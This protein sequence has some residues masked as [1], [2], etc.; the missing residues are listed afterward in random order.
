MRFPALHYA[1]HHRLREAWALRGHHR[2][3]RCIHNV[4]EGFEIGRS[5]GKTY[6]YEENSSLVDML[7]PINHDTT[8]TRVSEMCN[9]L[10][11]RLEVYGIIG[12]G[13]K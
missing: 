6:Q 13:S 2:I 5:D 10:G 11:R 12:S 7:D 1:F 9:L 8:V 3:S 4:F